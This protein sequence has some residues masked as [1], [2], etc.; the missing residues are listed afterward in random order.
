M[1][2]RDAITLAFV[3]GPHPTRL[4]RASPKRQESDYFELR[5]STGKSR[6]IEFYQ[7]GSIIK[8]FSYVK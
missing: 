2:V 6:V 3:P 1:P 8:C 7:D 5:N 4:C